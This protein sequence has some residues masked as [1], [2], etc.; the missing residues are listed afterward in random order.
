MHTVLEC[1]VDVVLGRVHLECIVNVLW[2]DTAAIPLYMHEGSLAA[3]LA[4]GVFC[5]TAFVTPVRG[6]SSDTTFVANSFVVT[7]TTIDTTTI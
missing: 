5:N 7:L 3:F 6:V 1:I 2:P 4:Q